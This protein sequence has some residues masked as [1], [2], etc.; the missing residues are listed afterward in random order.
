MYSPVRGPWRLSLRW[1]SH[2]SH[3]AEH[4][5]FGAIDTRNGV[6]AWCGTLLQRAQEGES[7]Q[8]H[9]RAGML[10]PRYDPDLVRTVARSAFRTP[11][12]L[13]LDIS[14]R[15]G[16]FYPLRF[17]K[18]ASVS[19]P[20]ARGVFRV[21]A[22]DGDRLTVDANHPLA[23]TPLSLAA[24][25][26]PADQEEEP[27]LCSEALAR[28]CG[29]GPGM[30][31][32]I[33]QATTPS[34]GCAD[35]DRED[36]GDDRAFYARP[37]FVPHIDRQAQQTIREFYRR[38]LSP[39]MRVLDLM[40]S[41]VS[42][43]PETIP[44]EVAGLGMNQ[45][46]LDANVRLTERVVQDLNHDT[47]LPFADQYFDLVVCTVSVEYLV[48]PEQIFQSIARVLKPEGR[49]AITFSDRCFPT[50]A[51]RIWSE[52]H[53]FERMA[54]VLGYFRESG[55]FDSLNTETWRGWPRPE[56]DKYARDLRSSDPVFAVWGRR[57]GGRS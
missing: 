17:L 57:S 53:P 56:D 15:L 2:D 5:F 41:W 47:A 22:L 30:Q 35:F 19:P 6:P 26:E 10:V 11:P 3:H 43:L 29:D 46:E 25:P 4:R 38:F 32:S 27:V 45:Q 20:Q 48:R 18:D 31:A 39:G 21:L 50:K 12:K 7:A 49:C 34:S 8:C 9:C 24:S 1:Q 42:H 54:W 37:R 52:L 55:R 36:E 33:P 23:K 51:I 16:R 14:P 28:L 40:S 13:A 44:L